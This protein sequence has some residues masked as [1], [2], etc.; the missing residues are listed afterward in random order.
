MRISSELLK[1]LL[2]PRLNSALQRAEFTEEV[3]VDPESW[4][5]DNSPYRHNQQ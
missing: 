5:A 3:L 4:H 2:D 1:H